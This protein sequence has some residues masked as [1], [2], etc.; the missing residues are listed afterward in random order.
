MK[1]GEVEEDSEMGDKLMGNAWTSKL[2][3]PSC[4]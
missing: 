1:S 2:R 4:L 3:N